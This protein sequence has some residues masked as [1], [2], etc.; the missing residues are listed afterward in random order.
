MLVTFH[1][2]CFCMNLFLRLS[3]TLTALGALVRSLP[4]TLTTV[5]A[6][7]RVALL[8]LVPLVLGELEA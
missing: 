5:P 1:Y 7:L 2:V 8:A 3:A 4:V 6:L